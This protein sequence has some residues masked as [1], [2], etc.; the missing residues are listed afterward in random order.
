MA[1]PQAVFLPLFIAVALAGCAAT[2][3]QMGSKDAK[4]TATGSAAGAATSRSKSRAR[5][6]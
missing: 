1:R 4:T 6:M 3:M 2:S 5:E